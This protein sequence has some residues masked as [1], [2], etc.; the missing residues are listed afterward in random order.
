MA[1]DPAGPPAKPQIRPYPAGDPRR[2]T[3]RVRA[4]GFLRCHDPRHHR[5]GGRCPGELLLLLPRQDR[6]VHRARYCDLPRSSGGCRD[7][8][9]AR[10]STLAT[11]DRGVGRS[12]L[13]LS[14]P[15]RGLRHPLGTRHATRSQISGRRSPARTV[16]RRRHSVSASPRSPP[17][18]W[19]SIRPRWDWLSWPCSSAA[20]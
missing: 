17:R 9:R 2:R 14:G 3:S 19:P 1:S 6:V 12:L 16:E 13:R 7:V 4:Q 20:G 5:S 18:P 15:Q 10:R 11:A 8:R